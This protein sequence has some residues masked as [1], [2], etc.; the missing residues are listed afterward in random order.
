MNAVYGILFV[1]LASQNA[2]QFLFRYVM[3][4]C[5]LLKFNYIQYLM[6]FARTHTPSKLKIKPFMAM[7]FCMLNTKLN[8]NRQL[9]GKQATNVN[10]CEPRTHGNGFQRSENERMLAP[11]PMNEIASI[12]IHAL[13]FTMEIIIKFAQIHHCYW[14]FPHFIFS[15]SLC[16]MYYSR[17]TTVVCVFYAKGVPK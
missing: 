17:T 10:K 12:D 1:A 4:K 3:N 2:I 6:V 11:T 16:I 15:C 14:R 7:V 5:D 8:E 13:K 9:A